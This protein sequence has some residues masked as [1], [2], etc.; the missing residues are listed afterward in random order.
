[1]TTARGSPPGTDDLLLLPLGRHPLPQD[2]VDAGEMAFAQ[3]SGGSVG[4]SGSL[5]GLRSR[6]SYALRVSAAILMPFLELISVRS[7]LILVCL[8]R[9]DDSGD[10]P[11]VKWQSSGL[12]YY[13]L[14]SQP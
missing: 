6:F 7:L 11:V 4:A 9:G 1:M 13:P 2:F 8:P 12:A 5:S 10:L 14:T 3:R